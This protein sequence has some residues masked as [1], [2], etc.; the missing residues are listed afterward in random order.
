DHPLIDQVL[1]I[2]TLP[3]RNAG[4]CDSGVETV[5]LRD[6]PHG[7]EPA[8]TPT[9]HAEAVGINL[10]FLNCGIDSGKV[11]AQIAAAQI[12]SIRAGDPF[13]LA[14]TSAWIGKQH[15]ITACR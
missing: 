12:S 9:H 2:V 4:T 5:G 13:T 7:H 8:V 14:V 10:I 1:A 15:V 11:V 6:G 3:I